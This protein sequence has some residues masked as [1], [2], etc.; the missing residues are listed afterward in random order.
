MRK[1]ENNIVQ[2]VP[3]PFHYIIHI[4]IILLRMNAHVSKINDYFMKSLDHINKNM[5]L[6]FPASQDNAG[7]K[8]EL[9]YF[10]I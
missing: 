7:G 4:F 1:Y 3:I 8:S 10:I 9:Q 5:V 6:L 2:R